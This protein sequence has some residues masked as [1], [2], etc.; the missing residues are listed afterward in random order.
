MDPESASFVEFNDV[1]H[2]Q[3]GYTREEFAK[4]TLYDILPTESPDYIRGHVK[5]LLQE[6]GGEFETVHQTKNGE[7]RNVVVT[8]KT[9]QSAGKKY[10]TCISRDVTEN[11]KTQTALMESE[12]RYRQLVE[13]AQEG[14]W[15]IDNDFLTILVNPRMAQMLGYAESEMVGKALFDFIDAQMVETIRGILK[16]FSVRDIKGQYDYAFPTKDGK[17][18]ETTVNMSRIIDDHG[19]CIGTLA[20]IIDITERKRME[21]ALKESEELSRAIVANAPLG[22]ATSDT[23]YHFLSANEAF[24]NILGYTEAELQK[25]TFKEITHPEELQESV[26]QVSALENREV[27]SIAREKRYI[28]KDGTTIVGRVIVN[29]LRDHA[30]NP[31]LFIVEL[32]DITKR[33][34]L[35]DDVK[36]SE[37]KFRAIS[38][39]ATDAIIL[40]DTD[41][42]VIYWNPA[43]EKI[44]GFTEKEAVGSKL[45]KLVI[46]PQWHEKQKVLLC[47]MAG[48]PLSRKHFNFNAFRKDGSK[49]PVDLSVVSV[50]IKNKTC[51]LSIVRDI[52]ESKAMEEA[53]RQERDMLESM[54]ANIDAG[55]TIINK[56]YRVLWGNQLMKKVS[57]ISAIENEY[58]YAVYSPG[59]CQVCQGCGVKKIFDEGASIS[60]HD[61]HFQRGDRD[62]WVELIATPVKDKEGNVVA[63]LELAVDITERK[64]LQNKLADYSQKLEELVQERTQ[65]LKKTQAELVKSERLAAIGEL[66]GMVGHDLRNPLTGIKNSAYYLRKK[67]ADIPEVQYREMLETINKCVDYSNRIVNDLLD[68][69]REIHLDLKEESLDKLL[70]ESLALL[71]VPQT[72]RIDNRLQNHRLVKVDPDKIKRLLINLMKNAVEAMPDGGTLTIES[73]ETNGN[74]EVSFADTGIGISENIL[75][76]LFSPL[77]TTKA[78]GMGFGLAICKRII[79]AHG[80]KITVNT[81]SGKG[82]TFTITL[83]ITQKTENG[84]EMIWINLPESSLSTTMK[85]LEQR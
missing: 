78:Q 17:R 76:K 43:A 69:S 7:N 24:C 37:E 10:L 67:G 59:A 51:L 44:L 31:L 58:C 19:K 32:E 42:N 40:S 20:V 38:N 9:F 56:D 29:S 46:P 53:L 13:V 55:L 39:S 48:A 85:Q 5:E 27:Q 64:L 73:A 83:P 79:E 14:I 61:F 23:S 36:A 34:Q 66:A 82:T 6:N 71:E 45:S 21:K 28:K 60:R 65:Q 50:K 25:L 57:G 81:A 11:K 35:E 4:L 77:C 15:A 41:D 74:L 2:L 70:S 30:G 63:A 3:L 8:V 52:T 22:I 47:E 16:E 80:G 72:I 49:F 75:P 54:A 26:V 18:V 68:Y 1:A 33:K 12:A 84:G 62:R